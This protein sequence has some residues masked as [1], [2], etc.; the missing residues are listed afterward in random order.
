MVP[1]SQKPPMCYPEVPSPLTDSLQ[2]EINLF[3]PSD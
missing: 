2:R 1:G 3:I